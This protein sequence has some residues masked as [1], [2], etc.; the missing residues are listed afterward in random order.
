M[1]LH[2]RAKILIICCHSEIEHEHAPA[3]WSVTRIL[4]ANPPTNNK[5]TMISSDKTFPSY[6]LST[7][8]PETSRQLNCEIAPWPCSNFENVL[9]NK[10]IPLLNKVSSP[11]LLLVLITL[12]LLDLVLYSHFLSYMKYLECNMILLKVLNFKK[13]W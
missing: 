4:A 12:S 1:A 6:P 13:H 3:R 7:K 5:N 10:A 9:V 8:Q 2:F 11:C